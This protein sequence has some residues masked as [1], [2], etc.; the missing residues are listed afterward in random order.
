MC[1]DLAVA[2]AVAGAGGE[3]MRIVING[4]YSI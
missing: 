1:H 4:I 2:G 3:D